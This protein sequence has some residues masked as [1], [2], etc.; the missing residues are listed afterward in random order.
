MID[1]VNILSNIC[2]NRGNYPK[3]DVKWFG[4]KRKISLGNIKLN[5]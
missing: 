3:H 1:D 2:K 4:H 5:L